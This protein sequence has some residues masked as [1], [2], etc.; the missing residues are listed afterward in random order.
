M[1][2]FLFVFLFAVFG[3]RYESENDLAMKRERVAETNAFMAIPYQCQTLRCDSE[4]KEPVSSQTSLLMSDFMMMQSMEMRFL[5]LIFF[6]ELTPRHEAKKAPQQSAS[7]RT[8][9]KKD[10]QTIIPRA[11]CFL[12]DFFLCSG[13]LSQYRLQRKSQSSDLVKRFYGQDKAK[14]C[15]FDASR[16]YPQDKQNE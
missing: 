8:R 13:S 10:T 11:T 3:S 6:F 4:H 15:F 16:R 7:E 9:H 12:R 5:L 1:N 14:K 2:E